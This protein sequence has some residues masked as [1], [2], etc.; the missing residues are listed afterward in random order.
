MW[1]VF[2]IYFRAL[3]GVSPTEVLAHRIAWSALFMAALVTG[4]RRWGEVARQLR[5]PG[6]PGALT[7]S[8]IFISLNWV[9]YI[10]AVGAGRVVEA[11]LGYF[12]NP[13]VSVLMGVVFLKEPL[14]GRQRAAVWLAAAGV[15][16]LMVHL[17][18]PPWVAIAL[19][20][21]FALYGLIRK[22]ATVDPMTGLLAEVV[23][24][25]PAALAWL[26]WLGATGRLAF[27]RAAPVTPLLLA[28]GVVTAV[29]LLLFA[30]GVRRLRLSTIGLLQYLNPTMQL[31]IAVFLFGE[32]FSRFHA[33]AFGLIWAG[34]GLYTWDALG[35]RGA[36]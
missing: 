35:R 11:S 18:Q 4:L 22:R 2:P 34:I 28:S 19:A 12:V 13:L 36:R 31:A 21:S 17:G 5:T 14:S 24:L 9:V 25:L 8:A 30:V 10:W 1:G 33:A 15:A 16:L 27:G 7:L 3:A 32:A 26:A 20:L 29:P 23:V 6:T